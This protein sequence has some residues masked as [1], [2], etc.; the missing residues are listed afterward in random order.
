MAHTIFISFLAERM[1]VSMALFIVEIIYTHSVGTS[2][3]EF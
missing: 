2:Y 3:D 1:G